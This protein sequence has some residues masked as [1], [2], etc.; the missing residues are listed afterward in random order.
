MSDGLIAE[1]PSE[2]ERR[3]KMAG[4]FL[5]FLLHFLFSTRSLPWSREREA[6]TPT[7]NTHTYIWVHMAAYTGVDRG[8]TVLVFC[9]RLC[10]ETGR[11]AINALGRM[12]EN[13]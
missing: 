1:T 7:K 13:F 5:F 2:M 11:W 9:T 6:H 12:V 8:R 4:F 10:R 3:R